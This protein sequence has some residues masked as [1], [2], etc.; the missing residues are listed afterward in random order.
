MKMVSP[1]DGHMIMDKIMSCGIG[2]GAGIEI[3]MVPDYVCAGCC[4]NFNVGK[5]AI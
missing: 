5:K 2:A 3:E 4:N 1:L